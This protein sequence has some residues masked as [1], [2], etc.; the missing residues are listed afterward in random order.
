M[1]KNCFCGNSLKYNDCCGAIHAATRKANT[2]EE[3]MRSRYSAFVLAD[4][5][6]ILKTYASDKCPADQKEEILNWAKSVEWL[7][8]E[9]ISSEK[10]SETDSIGWVEFK[11]SFKEDGQKQ[12]MH[13][14][15]LFKLESE[16]WVYVSGEV[17]EVTEKLKDNL[18]NRND[19][20]FCGSAKKYKKCCLQ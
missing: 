8:L 12:V 10:G 4:I 11:A 15:S 16:A 17:P 19:L 13:E 5:D 20:C 18:P 6:Y 14:R 2:A 1:D 7:G 3:L 9:I